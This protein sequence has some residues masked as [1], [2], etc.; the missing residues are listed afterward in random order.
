[1]WETVGGKG[2]QFV[3]VLREPMEYIYLGNKISIYG[4]KINTNEPDT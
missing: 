2:S 3:K 4:T 1:M